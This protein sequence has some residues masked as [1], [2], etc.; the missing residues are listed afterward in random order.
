MTSPRVT[1]FGR[2]LAFTPRQIFAPHSEPEL[3]AILKECCGRRIRTIGR[4]HCWS[5]AP[6]ADDVLL[7]L[8]HLNQVNV[9]RRDDKVWVTVGAGCQIKRLLS[10]LD[11]QQAGTLPTL[12]LITEQ[13]IAGAISTATHGSGSPSMSHFAEEIRVAAYDPVTGDPVIR[14]I[15]DGPELRAARCSLGAM[16]VIVSVSFWAKSQYHI[17]EVS[18]RYTSIEDVLAAEVDYPLQQFYLMPWLWQYFVHHRREVSKPRGGWASLYRWYFFVTFDVMLHV[19]LLLLVRILRSPRAIKFFYR[20]L[21]PR[22]VIENWAVVDKS[23][24]MLVMEHELFRHIEIELFVIRSDVVAALDFVTALLKHH[25]G[26]STAIDA[27]VREQLDELGLL[28]ELD[29]RC[30]SYTHHYPICVRR[31][32]P[33]DALISMTSGVG[34]PSYAISFISYAKPTQRESFMKFAE[35][36]GKSMVALFDARPHWGKV[37]P[38]SASEATRLYPGLPEFREICQAADPASVFRNDWINRTFFGAEIA[39]PAEED[40]RELA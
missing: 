5:E 40:P 35:F 24:E 9:E 29:E 20:Y 25:D 17:E 6:V 19:N 26:D 18:R 28:T 14:V 3:L 38:L 2:N 15:R 27:N 11:R 34:E 4:L 10:E 36:L 22:T 12:G 32:L 31:V 39:V 37:C 8:R 1:N 13:T 23:Q 7:D 16:G 30:G 33:D 21:A